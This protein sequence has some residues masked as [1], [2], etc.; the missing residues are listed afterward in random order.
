LSANK[1]TN[2]YLYLDLVR[3]DDEVTIEVRV[4]RPDGPLFHREGV[5]VDGGWPDHEGPA[6]RS[7]D[8]RQV[9]LVCALLRALQ[10]C[11]ACAR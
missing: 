6:A 10:A 2:Y 8:A 1:K 11:G 4:Y 7:D 5:P 9:R 3:D